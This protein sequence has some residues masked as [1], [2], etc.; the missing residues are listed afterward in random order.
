MSVLTMSS[1]RVVALPLARRS[2]GRTTW[3][4]NSRKVKAAPGQFRTTVRTPE[5][6]YAHSAS[7]GRCHT[8]GE[9][10]FPSTHNASCLATG[11]G[12][13]PKATTR[14][15][16]AILLTIQ[17]SGRLGSIVPVLPERPRKMRDIIHEERDGEK[18]VSVKSGGAAT[19][20]GSE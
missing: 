1:Q 18:L 13:K 20:I 16:W 5:S 19:G 14:V 4:Q 11:S 10:A 8:A 17:H 3:R 9:R 2:T 6:P 15:A 12:P 7:L